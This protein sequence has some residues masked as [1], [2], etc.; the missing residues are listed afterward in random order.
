MARTEAASGS[1]ARVL[2]VLAELPSPTVA[3]QSCRRLGDARG[4]SSPLYFRSAVEIF[5][6]WPW[7][8]GEST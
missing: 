7:L 5:L 6:F 3:S 4:E 8:P 2:D 1:S